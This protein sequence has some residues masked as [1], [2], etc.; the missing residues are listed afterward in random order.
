LEA[1][2]R[3]E[4]EAVELL[5]LR[6]AEARRI[7][8]FRTSELLEAPQAAQLEFE[9]L[10]DFHRFINN[11]YT[12]DPTG[13][14]EVSRSAMRAAWHNSLHEAFPFGLPRIMDALSRRAWENALYNTFP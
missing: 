8:E 11:L 6:I 2:Y 4:R 9:R 10:R 7:R 3:R 5:R 14:S 13:I 12:T 1:S